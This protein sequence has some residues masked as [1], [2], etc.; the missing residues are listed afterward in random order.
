[1]NAYKDQPDNIQLLQKREKQ[2]R[3]KIANNTLT[4][5]EEDFASSTGHTHYN[6]KDKTLYEIAE[7]N[8]QWNGM[9]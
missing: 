7:G 9:N 6:L 2:L 5:A 3:E 8:R 4:P 1:M